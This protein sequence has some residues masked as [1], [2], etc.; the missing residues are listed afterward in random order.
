MLKSGLPVSTAKLSLMVTMS[1]RVAAVVFG[2][3]SAALVGTFGGQ[4][5]LG[6]YSLIRVIL[7]IFVLLTSFGTTNAYPYLI[8][9]CSYEPNRVLAN[10]AVLTFVIGAAQLAL[11]LLLVPIITRI[12][13][14]EFEVYQVL[15][16]GLSAPFQ[17]LHLHIVHF[18]RSVDKVGLANLAFVSMELAIL[19]LIALFAAR[20]EISN[21]TIVAAI[22]LACL[23]VPVIYLFVLLRSG[24]SIRPKMDRRLAATSLRYGIK[25]QASGLFQV[26]NYRIDQLI[27]GGFLGATDLGLYA[28]ASKSAELFRFFSRSVSFAVEPVLASHTYKDAYVF[29]RRNR[30]KIFAANLLFMI[31]GLFLIPAVL[32]LV[33]GAWSASA[34]PYFFILSIGLIVGG[35]NGLMGA[36]NK[37]I[38]EPERNT[39]VVLVGLCSA[40]GLNLTLVPLMGISGA[41][42]ASVFAQLSIT[43]YF[44][45][46]FRRTSDKINNV[47]DP[48]L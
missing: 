42:W 23:F 29:V 31:F 11:W 22:V 18:L 41:A 33:F 30:W 34:T 39:R 1:A 2:A 13:L 43:V 19:V 37:A 40:L 14:K 12:F 16:V 4:T 21:E 6:Y 47:V 10:S 48:S 7:A 44:W 27:I 38:G 15:I 28:V 17:L 20:F 46:Q 8:R 5:L 32:P 24:Y 9:R 26:L 3:A 35:S 36:Y 45:T 25:T